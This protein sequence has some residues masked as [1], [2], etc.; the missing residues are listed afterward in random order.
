MDANL[1][2]L[3]SNNG[4]DAFGAD[5]NLLSS[6]LPTMIPG[7]L[8]TLIGDPEMLGETLRNAVSKYKPVIYT[9][10]EELFTCY[11]DLAN[12][13]R[14]FAAQAAMKHNAY[15]AYMDAGFS[16]EQA[17]LLLLD[18]DAARRSFMRQIAS[19]ISSTALNS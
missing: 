1:L 14:V 6:L 16:K 4:E 18:S 12:N 17:M 3:L 10:L 9:L 15:K 19:S 13:H 2:N 11:E 7:L 5:S 8:S